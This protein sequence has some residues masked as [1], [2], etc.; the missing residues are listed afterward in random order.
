[1]EL[2]LLIPRINDAIRICETSQ[3]PKFV[4]FLT[5]N[6]VAEIEKN[7]K[8]IITKYSFYGGYDEAERLFFGAFPEW[9]DERQELFPITP[10]T[11][12]YRECDALSHRDFLG[13]LM[14]LGLTRETVGDILVEK[15]RAVAFLSSDIADY[16]LSQLD[17]IARVGVKV[18][19]G[20]SMPLPNMSGFEEITDTVASP[21]LDCV[22]ASLSK[23][24]RAQ[25]EEFILN[26][27]VS[28]NSVCVTKTVKTVNEGD[29]ITIRRK[30]KFLIESLAQKT[31]KNRVIL[32]AKKYV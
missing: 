30:G 26:G 31:K 23:S 28:V 6:E 19:K 11:F 24:S 20:Y 32:I 8:S 15:G 17:K 9:C 12:T 10:V 5:S 3:A 7:L 2:D 13:A 16:V 29:K 21:R 14:S 4:G 1:M 18:E 27:F 22:V 25:A